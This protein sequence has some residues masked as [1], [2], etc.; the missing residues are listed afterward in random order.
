MAF[1][2]AA[3]LRWLSSAPDSSFRRRLHGRVVVGGGSPCVGVLPA[4]ARSPS[5]PGPQAAWAACR[6][7]THDSNA[8]KARACPNPLGGFIETSTGWCQERLMP[9]FEAFP[10]VRPGATSP[11]AAR[12]RGV[13]GA[14]FPSHA[15]GARIPMALAAPRRAVAALALAAAGCDPPAAAPASAAPA[16]AAVVALALWSDPVFRSEAEGAA[17]VL[18]GRYGHG[19]PVV[20][21]LQHRDVRDGER[22]GRHRG[23]AE[24]ARPAASTRPR[25]ADPA[26]DH[27]RLARGH[28]RQGRRPHRPRAAG[29]ASGHP[30]R[31]PVPAP[32]VDRVGL[33]RRHLHGAGLPRHAGDDG[34][35]QP[36]T[37]PSAASPRR[38]G[39]ISATPSSTRRSGATPRC[40][41]AFADARGIVAAREA[42]QGFDPSNPQMAGGGSRAAAAGGGGRSG[43]D[44]VGAT[45]RVTPPLRLSSNPLAPLYQVCPRAPRG[46][47]QERSRPASRP[48]VRTG[49]SRDLDVPIARPVV[50]RARAERLWRRLDQGAARPRRGAQAPRH[51]YRRYGRRLRPAPHDLRGR[52]QRHRRG[53]GGP[54][55]PRHR[56]AE[57][58]RLGQR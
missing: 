54:R 20:V 45:V 32:R 40:T 17:K 5:A 43:R 2:A 58:G 11:G 48:V 50:P 6:L 21:Q 15:I 3:A 25:R 22:A 29:R 24:A 16:K 55:R 30:R 9:V 34:G 53:A 33:L 38:T 31:E 39:P 57:R 12:G 13:L 4:A 8:K 19:G 1:G 41:A 28:G 44:P 23:G 10:K 46:G 36:R 35:R 56:D 14:G 42:K 49:E 51:V 7:G 47:P 18:A 52:R 27:P 26:A 37:P